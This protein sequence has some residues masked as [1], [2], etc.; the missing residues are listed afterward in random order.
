M[1]V[2]SRKPAAE[3]SEEPMGIVI[4]RGKREDVPPTFWAYVWAEAAEVAEPPAA[5]KAA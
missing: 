2:S 5:P 1:P 3:V 4:S